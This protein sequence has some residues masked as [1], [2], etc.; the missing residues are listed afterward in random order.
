VTKGSDFFAEEVAD[1]IIMSD[2]KPVCEECY[3]WHSDLM[4]EFDQDDEIDYIEDPYE[5]DE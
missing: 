4:S 1:R 3:L 5:Y 2:G